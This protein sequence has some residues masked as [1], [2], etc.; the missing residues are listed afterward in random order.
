VTF[1]AWLRMST[2]QVMASAIRPGAHCAVMTVAKLPSEPP[3]PAK[4]TNSP[5][6]S[7]LEPTK[8]RPAASATRFW[9]PASAAS[10]ARA[11]PIAAW[12]STRTLE[13]IVPTGS[14]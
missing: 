6:T 4:L 3:D 9:Y 14:P 5:I 2:P 8:R 10:V 7:S 13:E 12:D 11:A 1:D